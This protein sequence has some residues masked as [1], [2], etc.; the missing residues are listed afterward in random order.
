[1]FVQW[2]YRNKCTEKS[3]PSSQK[4]VRPDA[5]YEQF[6]QSGSRFPHNESTENVSDHTF[7]KTGRQS[8]LKGNFYKFVHKLIYS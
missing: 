8:F 4:D 1:M 3:I 6:V 2:C 5:C 7:G